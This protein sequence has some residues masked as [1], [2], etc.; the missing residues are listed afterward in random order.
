M[1][2]TQGNEPST[3]RIVHVH[4]AKTA[5]V[6]LSD[7][8]R[9]A[10]GDRL[11]FHPERFEP[12]WSPVDYDRYDFFGGHVGFKVA[13][14][15][16][17]D[18]IT[19][20]RDPIDRFLSA[21]YYFRQRYETAESRNAKTSLAARFDLDQFVQIRDEP[22][23]IR[24]LQDRMLWQLIISHLLDQRQRVLDSGVTTDELVPLALSNL[25]TFAIVGLQSNMPGLA[26]AINR[27]YGVS[28]AI[29][30][31]NVTRWRRLRSEISSG[32]LER[33]RSWVALDQLLYDRW[34]SETGC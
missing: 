9:A 1:D 11:R 6:A 10:F 14:E 21:Y 25:R 12:K 16:G 26:R 24:D 30:H 22:L 8:F 20:L 15:I 5:G 7:A 17:G 4:I 13:R 28:L 33:I 3:P 32:T 27:R 31:A 19:V 18:L 29:G 2:E 23:L 34:L